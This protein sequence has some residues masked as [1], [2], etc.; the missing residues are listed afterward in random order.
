MEQNSRKLVIFDVDGTLLDNEMGGLKDLL[1][2]LGKE[3]EVRELDREYQKRKFKGP[4]GLKEV[5]LLYKG[6]NREKLGKLALDYCKDNL[7]QGAQEAVKHFKGKGAVVGS[8]SS[9]P[10]FLLNVLKDILSLDFAYGLELEFKNNRATGRILREVDRFTKAEI[11]KQKMKELAIENRDVLVVGDSVADVEM[12]K[13][14]GEFIAITPDKAA[15]KEAS[16]V[17]EKED[18]REI[19]KKQDEKNQKED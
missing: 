3:K 11:L 13:E 5:A 17:I 16:Q 10:Q 2:I 7:K 19:F 14:A 1:V 4:W 6:F 9:N 15:K 18:L 8:I 12:A